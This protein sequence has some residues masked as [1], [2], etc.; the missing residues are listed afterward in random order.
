MGKRGPKPRYAEPEDLERAINDYFDQCEEQGVFPDEAGMRVY[1]NLSKSR[2]DAL[3]SPPSDSTDLQ[4][5]IQRENTRESTRESNNNNYK[6]YRE[7]LARARDRRESWLAR[8][9][10]STPKLA[11]GCLNALKQPSNGG[12]VDKNAGEQGASVSITFVGSKLEE[13]GK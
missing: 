12:W 1:L 4:D 13:I 5:D 2:L 10:T 9:A 11:Q 7:I 6:K 8:T 3:A